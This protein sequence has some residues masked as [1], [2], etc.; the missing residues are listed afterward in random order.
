MEFF[1]YTGENSCIFRDSFSNTMRIAGEQAW[2]DAHAHGTCFK[3]WRHEI[4]AVVAE[5]LIFL[6]VYRCTFPSVAEAYCNR[7]SFSA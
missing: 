4:R 3:A 6:W 1:L 2:S 5:I 7:K